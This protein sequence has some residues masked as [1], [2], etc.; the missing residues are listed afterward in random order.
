MHLGKCVLLGDAVHL[1]SCYLEKWGQGKKARCREVTLIKTFSS[2]YFHFNLPAWIDLWGRDFWTWTRICFTCSGINSLLRRVSQ[3]KQP[4]LQNH[5]RSLIINAFKHHYSQLFDLHS[6]PLFVI[7]IGTLSK[8]LLFLSIIVLCHLGMRSCG[9]LN[10]SHLACFSPVMYS[11]N[12]FEYL[13]CIRGTKISAKCPLTS[14]L[15]ERDING[16]FK[17]GRYVHE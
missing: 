17:P 6:P 10:A 3:E 8:S 9:S 7:F 14:P 4:S 2:V 11:L 5:V 15:A 12:M 16:V 13:S 1:N